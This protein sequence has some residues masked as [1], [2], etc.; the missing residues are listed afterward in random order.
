MMKKLLSRLVIALAASVLP[1]QAQLKVGVGVT[2]G[3]NINNM[4]V[5]DN[6]YKETI[7]DRTCK[8]KPGF[9]IGPTAIFTL[10]QF[11]LGLDVSA[12]YDLRAVRPK[13]K[14]I[15][16]K[17]TNQ[18]LQ[19]PVNVRYGFMLG[20]MVQLFV[21]GGP[22]FGLCL[23]KKGQTVLEGT[24]KDGDAMLLNWQPVSSAMSV[25]LGVGGVVL[26]RVQVKIGYNFAM[27]ATGEFKRINTV[28]GATR[29]LE[30]GKLHACQVM[31][32]YLF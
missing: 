1:V 17:V 8:T 12:L 29:V 4:H 27:D 3:L 22:Q 24:N 19:I 20:D 32:S 11:G 21:Y 13:K 2:G 14:S 23:K 26:D 25:N 31:V 30:T 15:D 6:G 7:K 18:T 16:T 5:S 10:P 9:V 28:T